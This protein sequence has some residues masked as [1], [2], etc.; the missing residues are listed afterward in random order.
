M[1]FECYV[2]DLGWQ[3]VW[4]RNGVQ[5]QKDDN[6]DMADDDSFLNIT[7]AKEHEGEYSCSLTI[8]S[9]GLRSQLSNKEIIT[10]YG[11]P[12]YIFELWSF[13]KT[14]TLV[15]KANKCFSFNPAFFK[16]E[17]CA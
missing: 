10:V 15:S 6:V 3:F 16:T 5:L 11:K 4:Y 7:A 2:D 9:R 8:S 12:L 13:S 1:Q 14:I 17:S